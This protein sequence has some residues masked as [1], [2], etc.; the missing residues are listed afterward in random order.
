MGYLNQED[1]FVCVFVGV[2]VCLFVCWG[3]RVFFFVCFIFFNQYT[4]HFFKFRT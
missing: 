2:L 3:V 4:N 1:L